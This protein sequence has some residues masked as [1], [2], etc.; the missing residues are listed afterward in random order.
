M[1]YYRIKTE[2]TEE[3]NDGSLSKIKVEDLVFATSYTEAEKVAYALIEDLART[4]FSETISFE[5]VR[6]KIEEVL[7]S[8]IL[9]NDKKL[10]AGLV[11]NYF[12]EDEDSGV[13]LYAV[14]VLFIETDEKGKTRK[15]N[16]VIYTP[17]TSSA[18]AS[19]II[20]EHLKAIETRDF[21]IR[22]I[23]FDKAESILWPSE[24]YQS[25]CNSYKDKGAA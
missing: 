16:E 12:V 21:L 20:H 10:I 7:Y 9:T 18:N 11:Y 19:L 15:T 6:T 14:K 13:G 1:D 24:T 22:D 2:Y 4:Q 25:K 23:K 5:I 17:A 8:P 3:M